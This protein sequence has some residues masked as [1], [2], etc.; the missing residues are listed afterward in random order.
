M[1]TY[2]L[3]CRKCDPNLDA[4]MPFPSPEERGRWASEHTRGTGHDL[5]LVYDDELGEV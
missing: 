2:V 5:W 4:P 3:I 1:I